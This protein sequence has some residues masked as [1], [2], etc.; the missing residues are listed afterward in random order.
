MIKRVFI[1]A[2]MMAAGL[3]LI[4]QENTN[5]FQ[6]S[7]EKLLSTNGNLL[8]G[9]YG[10]VHYNQPLNSEISQNARL[11]VHRLVMLFGYQFN[12]RTQFVSE[13][14]FEH[15][16]EV[17]VEQAFLQHTISPAVNFRAGLM[18]IPM[19][20]INEYHEPTTFF[21]VE[22]PLTDKYIVPGT[23]REIGLGFSGTYLPASLKYQLYLV[24]GFNGYDGEAQFS[25]SSGLRGGRQKG[26]ESFMTSPALAARVEYFGLR[27]INLGLS[28][29]SGKSQTSL[30]D[31]LEKSD[32]AALQQA[33][34]SRIHT[35]MLGLDIRYTIKALQFKSQFY[36]SM[37][38]NTKQYNEFTGS[39][40][41][42]T[43]TGMYAEAGYNVLH[44]VNS[45][46]SELIPFFRFQYL[47]THNS[48]SGDLA[49]N[50]DFERRI[51]TAGINYKPVSGA[52]FKLDADFIKES[53][54]ASYS[55]VLNAGIGVM[56]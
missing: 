16:K 32:E 51:L 53:G 50:P 13:L 39:K 21:S 45:T 7:A 46:E 54:S 47:N 30:Y 44:H 11:D 23:W 37:L 8:I 49:A 9:G 17:Y 34:S 25:G 5:Q 33:D 42:E 48:T 20:I 31:G 22:R 2:V 52:V 18:L 14:E 27:G 15:V 12:D 24:N 4:A 36:Y 29:Y 19:G 56:F 55:T 35:N 6:N 41:G 10:E 43:M 3:S 28:A 1:T 38:D 40:L 26:A